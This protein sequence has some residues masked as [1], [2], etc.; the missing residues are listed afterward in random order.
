MTV[1]ISASNAFVSP[2]VSEAVFPKLQTEEMPQCILFGTGSPSHFAFLDND[3]P[4]PFEFGGRHYTCATAAYEAHKFFH[5]SDLMDRFTT[6]NAQKALELSAEKHFEKHSDWYALREERMFHVLRAKFGQNPPL[7]RLLLLTADAYLSAHTPFKG[8][9]PYWTD[10]GDGSGLNRQG[11]LLMQI[12]KEYGGIG[13]T[14]RLPNYEQFILRKET[15]KTIDCQLDKPSGE[16]MMEI[17][18]LNRQIDDG[19]YKLHSQIARQSD[20]LPFTRFPR[21]NFPYDKTLVPLSSGRYINASFVFGKQFIGTQSPMHHTT[22]DFWSMILEHDVSTVIMLNRLGDPGD[23]IYFPLALEDKKTYG[24][25]HLELVEPPFFKTEPSWRQSPHE[26]EPHA[27]IHRKLIVS[28]EGEEPRIVHHFQYQNWRDF[29]AGNER[30]VAY[31]VK[32]VD[33][34]RTEQ[35]MSPVTIHCH[36]GVGR[37]SVMITLLDQ[38]RAAFSGEKIDIKRSVERQRSP[39]E[40][41]CNSMMQSTDQYAFCYRVLSL[42]KQPQA[43]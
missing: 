27:V 20:H 12:R 1:P 2:I 25:I 9:D 13:E 17:G 26:E 31:L 15:E 16:I 37:T 24:K 35:P 3:Y 36:A 19:D 28:N 21:N 32:T 30:A 14:S 42:L 34:V 4:S 10:N 11:N 29:S 39:L 18:E 5:R 22:E 40:G 7:Q 6:L 43:V 41:R 33:A 23:D 38:F 8:M